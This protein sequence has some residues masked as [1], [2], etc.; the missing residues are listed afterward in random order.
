[1]LGTVRVERI[2]VSEGHSF[3]GR[4]GEE[5][6]DYPMIERDRVECVEGRGIRGDRFFDFKEDYKGQVTFFSREV[7]EDLCACCDVWDKSPAVFRRNVIVSGVDLND[8]V[9]REFEVQ[10]VRFA[11]VSECSP[12]Y[13]MDR[14]F[15][16]GA[17]GLLQGRGGLRARIVCSG[18]LVRDE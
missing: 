10:G 7:Y 6:L 3:F 17:E 16:D 2:Y 15:A 9:G 18:V 8:L 13:W 1:M 12:C 4:H 14:A 11:G 5:P